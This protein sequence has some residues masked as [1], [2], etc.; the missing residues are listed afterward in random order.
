MLVLFYVCGSHTYGEITKEELACG[1]KKFGIRNKDQWKSWYTYAHIS[2]VTKL[3][4]IAARED[5]S[6]YLKFHTFTYKYHLVQPGQKVLGIDTAIPLLKL[7]MLKH[8][9]MCEKFI[10]FLI[11]TGKQ[12]LTF[13]QWANTLD[14]FPILQAGEHYD[15]SGACILPLISQ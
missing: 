15:I 4:E 7:V 13:D 3:T 2:S 9:P 6:E 8:F 12:V 1:L 11:A 5:E 14:I 10:Q